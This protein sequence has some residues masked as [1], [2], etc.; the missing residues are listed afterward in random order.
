MEGVSNASVVDFEGNSSYNSN[1]VN[2]F[3]VAY[4]RLVFIITYA[5]VCGVCVIGKF[6]RLP[7]IYLS[8]Q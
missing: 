6:V 7:P 8:K 1:F 4:V 3:S 2:P 5:G